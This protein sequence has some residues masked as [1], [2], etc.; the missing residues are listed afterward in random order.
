MSAF[1]A[2]AAAN[3]DENLL[4]NSIK[5]NVPGGTVS[6]AVTQDD[7][8]A[9]LQVA[10]TGP[11]SSPAPWPA[12]SSRSGAAARSAPA[13]PAAQDS[14]CRSS[15]RSRRTHGANLWAV[16]CSGG[17]GLVVQVVYPRPP[18]QM[19]PVRISPAMPALRAG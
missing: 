11:V 16:P 13:T 19:P 3:P 18:G 6:L 2:R 4:D 14:V 8:Q 10:N 9:A 15:A 1:A 17:G 12:C 5:H 7:G